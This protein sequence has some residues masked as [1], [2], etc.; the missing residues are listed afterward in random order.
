MELITFESEAFKRLMSKFDQIE[1]SIATAKSRGPLTET[2]LDIQE[3][4]LLLKISKRTLQSYRDNGILS[5]SQIAGKI[6]FK[7]SDIEKHLQVHYI[8]S[9]N[10]I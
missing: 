10:K 4:C 5:Y 8:K 2:W 7:A 9:T 3:T 1:Q 6:Y